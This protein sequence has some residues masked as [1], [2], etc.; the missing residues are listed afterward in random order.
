MSIAYG[1]DLKEDRENWYTRQAYKSN[2]FF[3]LGMIPFKWIVDSVPAREP[4]AYPPC[5]LPT[6]SAHSVKHLPEWTPGVR[7][8]QVAR[9]SRG[10]WGPLLDVPYNRVKADMVI[11]VACRPNDVFIHLFFRQ[12]ILLHLLSSRMYY[13]ACKS[14]TTRCQPKWNGTSKALLVGSTQV[15]PLL[16]S[17]LFSYACIN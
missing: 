10:A 7:F 9:D 5:S 8:H 3:S 12:T 1:L 2:K 13:P 4:C 16:Y 14:Q 6:I 15:C 11:T 17:S